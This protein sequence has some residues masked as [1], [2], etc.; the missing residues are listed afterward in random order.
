MPLLA[1]VTSATVSARRAGIGPPGEPSLTLPPG[2]VDEIR[3]RALEPLGDGYCAIIG[4]YV[5]RDPSLKGLYGR[6]LYGHL[7]KPEIRSVQL[8]HGHATG[9]ASTGLAVGSMSS[10]GEDTRGR[11]YAVSLEGPV[12]RIAAR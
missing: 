11:T 2:G 6:Y 8:S 4:G 12:Y 9:D 7:C 10:L 3:C 5:V 1:P